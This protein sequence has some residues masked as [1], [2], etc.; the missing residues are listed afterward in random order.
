METSGSN[1][2]SLTVK[3]VSL[4]L[5]ATN[6]RWSSRVDDHLP[7]ILHCVDF[8]AS[9]RAQSQKK[10]KAIECMR[11]RRERVLH[12]SMSHFSVNSHVKDREIYS[13]DHAPWVQNVKQGGTPTS[14]VNYQ[15]CIPASDKRNALHMQFR[16]KKIPPPPR[17]GAAREEHARPS[18]TSDLKIPLIVLPGD[19]LVRFE[20]RHRLMDVWHLCRRCPSVSLTWR[21]R[22]RIKIKEELARENGRVVWKKRGEKSSGAAAA[23][24]FNEI[25][26]G[27]RIR[28]PEKF[29]C[30]F[31]RER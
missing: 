23:G 4:L 26:R 19:E 10:V 2:Q 20:R 5:I 14:A 13:K 24:D 25:L 7:I 21:G 15:R 12:F 29:D 3:S 9:N 1:N 30:G 17:K 22:G 11:W 6:A 31:K 8:A 16:R 28:W 18:I 27:E